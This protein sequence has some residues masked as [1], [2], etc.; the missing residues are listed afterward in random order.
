MHTI[1]TEHGASDTL[2]S[3]HAI[4]WM[5]PNNIPQGCSE[6][7]IPGEQKGF[8][9]RGYHIGLSKLFFLAL[10]DKFSKH[11]YLL[12]IASYTDEVLEKNRGD[13]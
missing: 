7:V 9:E 3:M 2:N 8:H 11:S 1:E 12:D 5:S 13:D 6:L 4:L 10:F